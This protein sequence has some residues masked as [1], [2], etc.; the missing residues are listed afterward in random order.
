MNDEELRALARAIAPHSYADA[1]PLSDDD[2][3]NPTG[4]PLR[5]SVNSEGT[6]SQWVPIGFL[7]YAP[8]WRGAYARRLPFTLGPFELH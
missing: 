5:H 3:T 2:A 6:G 1:V 8:L 4:I 7:P